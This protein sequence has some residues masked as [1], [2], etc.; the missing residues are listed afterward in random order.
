MGRVLNKC[1]VLR[2]MRLRAHAVRGGRLKFR[3]AHVFFGRH[4]L[5]TLVRISSR[6]LVQFM[7][8]SLKPAFVVVHSWCNNIAVFVA[9]SLRVNSR[10]DCFTLKTCF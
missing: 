5:M 1:K 7:Y 9:S 8:Q 2:D 4:C 6:C 10:E 3:T